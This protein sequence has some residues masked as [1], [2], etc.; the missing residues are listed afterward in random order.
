MGDL[1]TEGN[2]VLHILYLH[3]T[4]KCDTVPYGMQ[5][6]PFSGLKSGHRDE[7]A[8]W[9]LSDYTALLSFITP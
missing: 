1:F 5:V 7:G 6:L 2:V 9:Y 8:G 4:L 3:G